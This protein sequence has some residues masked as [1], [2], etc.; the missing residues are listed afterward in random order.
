MERKKKERLHIPGAHKYPKTKLETVVTVEKDFVRLN[1]YFFYALTRFKLS[2]LQ[3]AAFDVVIQRCW[4]SPDNKKD[5]E[6]Y[7]TI[8][9]SKFVEETG[10]DKGNLSKAIAQ[11]KASNMIKT[12]KNLEIG[13]KNEKLFKINKN[14]WEWL[15][16]DPEFY[17]WC[18]DS[19]LWKVD[20]SVSKKYGSWDNFREHR[21]REREP[22]PEDSGRANDLAGG[23]QQG[24]GEESDYEQSDEELM[25]ELDGV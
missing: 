5:K 25:E 6:G 3:R 10:R 20:E 18:R 1:K 21:K 11:I 7:A 23:I 19:K 17:H 9:L 15:T 4:G 14:Y 12:K 24:V 2:G 16:D 22:Q 13:R 8:P